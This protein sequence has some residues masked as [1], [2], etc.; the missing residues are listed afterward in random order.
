MFVISECLVAVW[1]A[2]GSAGRHDNLY[3]ATSVDIQQR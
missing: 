1:L 2:R 3:I